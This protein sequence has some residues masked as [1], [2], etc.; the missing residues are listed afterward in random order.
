MST[1]IPQIFFKIFN[2]KI[3]LKAMD[4]A[5]REFWQ[6]HWNTIVALLVIRGMVLIVMEFLIWQLFY[7]S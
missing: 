7:H 3:F 5:A 2:T 1:K 6:K 4:E